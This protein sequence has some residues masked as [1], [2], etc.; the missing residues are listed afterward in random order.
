MQS[1]PI[2]RDIGSRLPGLASV[3]TLHVSIIQLFEFSVFS[4]LA[5]C[6]GARGA[7]SIARCRLMLRARECVRAYKS[8][9]VLRILPFLK[10][11]L[12][13]PPSFQLPYHSVPPLPSFLP[14]LLP[15]WMPQAR[16]RAGG[17]SGVHAPG[18]RP[19]QRLAQA[20][21]RPGPHAP[22]R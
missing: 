11:L 19:P 13:L 17:L 10:L 6:C 18:G 16:S 7:C 8:L 1:A 14:S 2:G 9:H 5:D 20:L 22:S 4:Q 3:C 12:V 21:P 15:R